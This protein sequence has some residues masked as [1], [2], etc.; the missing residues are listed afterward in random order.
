MWLGWRGS[1]LHPSTVWLPITVRAGERTRKASIIMTHPVHSLKVSNIYLH[2][3]GRDAIGKFFSEVWSLDLT[4]WPDLEWPG[5]TIFR[6][7]AEQLSEHLCKK[8]R[9][10]CA[11]RLRHIT[12]SQKKNV[13]S[14][15][16]Q[17]G[18]KCVKHEETWHVEASVLFPEAIKSQPIQ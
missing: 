17:H 14:I 9:W 2:Y 11:G 1:R 13:Q 18:R 5:P 7:F 16:K 4:W 3:C 10:R 6:K 8:K 15:P 12:E